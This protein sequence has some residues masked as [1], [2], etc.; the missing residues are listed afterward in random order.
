[1]RVHWLNVHIMYCTTREAA[2][3]G[4][5]LYL[6]NRESG[7]GTKFNRQQLL[8]CN[9]TRVQT[10]NP[11]RW[12]F[13]VAEREDEQA[14]YRNHRSCFPTSPVTA[15]PADAGG[16]RWEKMIKNLRGAQPRCGGASDDKPFSRSRPQRR[17]DNDLSKFN[18]LWNTDPEES[19]GCLSQQFFL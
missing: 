2:R 1:M 17:F 8:Y 3:F 10:H 15:A 5:V 7:N 16:W 4:R 13:V 19:E 12:L 6:R 18:W 14:W 9:R 11:E